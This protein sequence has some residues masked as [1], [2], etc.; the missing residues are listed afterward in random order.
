MFRDVFTFDY[1]AHERFV[2]PA[3]QGAA[4]LWRIVLALPLAM[5]LTWGMARLI[6][7]LLEALLSDEQYLALSAEADMLL[8]AGSVLILLFSFGLISLSLG[9]VVIVIHHRAASTLLGPLG[10]MGRQFMR[11]SI[12]CALLLTLV[13][14][15]PPWGMEKPLEAGMPFSRWLALLVPGLLA[16]LIQTSA[17]ELLFRGYLQQQ[18]AARFRH[19]LVWLWL[20]STLFGLAHYAPEIYGSNAWPVALWAMLF[21]LLAADLTARTGTLGPAIGLHFINNCAALLLI[22]P[23][24]E[25]SGLALYLYPFDASDEEALRAFLPIDFMMMLLSW[26][27]ARIALRV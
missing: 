19:P 5:L 27:A 15:L 25:M 4:Q 11:S 26:L 20:P 18:L 12:A 1:A 21:G 8:S 24:G 17:E 23:Q 14:V 9:L 13:F 2:D 6:Q 7:S 10:V 16:V 22:A 3:R